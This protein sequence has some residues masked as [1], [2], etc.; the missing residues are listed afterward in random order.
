MTSMIRSFV[1]AILFAGLL[2]VTQAAPLAGDLLAAGRVDEA[3]ALLQE[4]VRKSPDGAAYNYLARA[5]FSVGDWDRAVAAGE[6][7]VQLTPNSS[8]YYLWLGQAYGEK[9]SHVNPFSAM[10]LAG[11][12]RRAFERAVEL[13]PKNVEAR[14]SLAEFYI[15]APGIVGGGR[16]KARAQADVLASLAPAKAH[17]LNGR[18]AEKAKDTTKAEKEYKAAIEASGGNANDWL[19]LALYYKHQER[20]D[21]M[22]QTL[23]RAANA[24]TASREVLVECAEILVRTNRNLPGAA[25]YARRFVSSGPSLEKSPLF[26]AHYVLGTVLEKQG[27]KTAAAQ[28]YRAA[29]ATA[30]TFEPAQKALSRISN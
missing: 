20:F 9:A 30:S 3:I 18:L 6:K 17:Y 2:P 25:E 11:K 22:E 29:L 8:D 4:Q 27:N 1:V 5:Y 15:D 21:E 24:P 19:N 28:E 26:K 7:S 23:N 10:S 13:D 16:D 14:T 12:A